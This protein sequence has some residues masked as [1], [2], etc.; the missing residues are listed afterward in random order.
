MSSALFDGVERRKTQR[1]MAYNG[2]GYEWIK[3]G[4]RRSFCER[5]WDGVDRWNGQR[6]I[7]NVGFSWRRRIP[8]LTVERSGRDRRQHGIDK[9]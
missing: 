6:R 1:R 3:M 8:V 5:R 2:D 4:Q 7:Q 9:L